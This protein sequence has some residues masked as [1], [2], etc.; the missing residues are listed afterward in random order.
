M[1]KHHSLKSL[2]LSSFRGST[3]E[4]KILFEKNRKLTLIYGENGCGKTTICDA[5][6]FLA[7]EKLGSLEGR[8]MGGGLETY[9]HS[10]SK[11]PN[12]LEVSLETSSGVCKG[13]I[14][15]NKAHITS[16]FGKP[17]I[18][19]LRRQQILEIIEAQP[20]KRYD[21]I[22]RFID[23][24][25]FEQSEELLRQNLKSLIDEIAAA[26][27]RED[28][29][30]IALNGFFEAAN[31]PAGLNPVS[32]AKEQLKLASKDTKGEISAIESLQKGYAIVEAHSQQFVE[33]VG[34]RDIAKN[35][36]DAAKNKVEAAAKT[37]DQG[38][39]ELL[40]LLNAARAI[41]HKHEKIDSCPLCESAE[42]TAG[43][44]ERIE[45]KIESLDFL[46]QVIATLRITESKL[47]TEEDLLAQTEKE[48][49]ESREKLIVALQGP[50]WP[51]HVSI[52]K[53]L[54]PVGMAEL[55]DW[56]EQASA[57][58]NSWIKVEDDLR[59]S[60]KFNV[61]L[62]NAVEQYDTNLSTRMKLEALQPRV[63]R[64]LEICVEERQAFTD[65]II[66][67]IAQTVGKLYEQ[68][69]PGEGLDKIALPLDPK[70]RASIE[71]KADFAGKNVPPQAYFSQSHLDTL[72]LCVFI[73]LALRT[74]PES[75]VLLLDDVLGSV[76]E[77]HVGRVIE[78]IY[79]VS[80]QF[81][82]AIV[83]TH[84]RPWREK[85][86][87]GFL[88]P[89]QPCQF[90]EL[91]S[92]TI[93]DGLRETSSLPEIERLKKLL[94]TTPIDTQAVCSKAGVILE[95]T[96][97]FLTQRFE[98]SVPRRLGGAYTLGDLLPAIKGKLRDALIAVVLVPDGV[99]GFDE[100]AIPLKPILDS[101]TNIA[102]VRNA[103][104][105]HFKEISFDLLDADATN[106]AGYVVS[107]VEA[108]THPEHGWPTNDN[109]GSYW[110]NSGDTR[111]LH[112]LKK[113]S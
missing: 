76:D 48:Y 46:N 49:T 7:E 27:K 73:A 26:R 6:Q 56:I 38:A 83:T 84:Y 55:L 29:N 18:E 34:K 96:L 41:L 62:K 78:M 17:Q 24:D 20:A 45:T 4:F 68:V 109:S 67:E 15:N 69:H 22:K 81:Q 80:Q 19:L 85:Y 64:T 70:K 65:N 91:S 90:V 74:S 1:T 72:G 77:P 58:A 36:R 108:L 50:T 79:E 54:P 61:A 107:L 66:S 47:K 51:E 99:G 21:A 2:T 104:G 11:T 37:I 28:E 52:P 102:Q 82:H 16:E 32:W 112:P 31:K 9:W 39:T 40:Q 100:N 95:A 57:S 88:K 60:D 105:A 97:D 63:K 8:G 14:S 44:K 33:R 59:G 71:L 98:C 10:S 75:K 5:F 113:P 89:D 111:R 42:K 53:E 101:L 12:D 3:T 106:F 35:E 93:N 13:K 94:A 23:V 110:R 43:L 92:W 30:L 103:M 87:W 86:R 25:N